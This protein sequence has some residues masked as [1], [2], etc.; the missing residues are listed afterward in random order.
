MSEY[1][2]NEPNAKKLMESLRSSG[3]DNYSAIADLTDNSF[4]ANADY[5]KI[6]YSGNDERDRILTICDNGDGMDLKTLNEALRLG[7]ETGRS[8][9][10]LGKYGLGLITASIS[11]GKR[12]VVIT[13]HDGHFYTGIHDLEDIYKTEKFV[14]EI[15][16]S[17]QTEKTAFLG[18]LGHVKSGTLITIQKIDNLQNK[19]NT[20]FTN[21]LVKK[22]GEVFRD[23]INANKR[24]AVNEKEVFSI[25]PMIRSLGSEELIDET[26]DFTVDGEK[27]T[28]RLR[29]FHLPHYGQAES[30][31]RGVN[32]PNQGFYLMRNNRQIAR[33]ES[34]GMFTKH[35][36]RNRFR[37]E[38]YFT[39]KLDKGIGV[40]FKKQDISLSEEIF[41]W[42]RQKSSPQIEA[43][44]KIAAN[45]ISQDKPDVDHESSKRVIASKATLL[46]KPR[47]D[48]S[49]AQGALKSLRSDQFTDID[50]VVE[51]NTHLAP[52]FQIDLSGKRV[53]IRYNSDHIFYE[54]VLKDA[55]SEDK[56]LVNSIDFLTY[57][58]ALSLINITSTEETAELKDIF[59][60]TMSDNLRALLS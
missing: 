38:I 27:S 14:K 59:V 19:N 60:D 31:D 13:K 5:V 2:S 43:I 47:I 6:N 26:A 51:R 21:T 24:I 48:T 45:K 57:S 54:R 40:N 18:K 28:L 56:D 12:L 23:F 15:R 7:S 53:T 41:Q 50:I 17:S 33:G 3:Y 20:V 30:K 8:E 29:I 10:D 52:L 44:Y 1:I 39:G 49:K 58:M 34:L 35:N 16:E 36:Y 55:A 4:D 46:K 32:I 22:L 37:A 9:E 11:I 25:D 42:V